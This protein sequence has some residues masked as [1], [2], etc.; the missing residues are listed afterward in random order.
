LIERRTLPFPHRA[1]CRRRNRSMCPNSPS[2]V[3]AL[4]ALLFLPANPR[5]FEPPSD[6]AAAAAT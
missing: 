6:T 3:L 4:L 5:E 1:L 2:S